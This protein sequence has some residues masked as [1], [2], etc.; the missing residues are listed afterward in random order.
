MNV[1]IV[2][3]L[4]VAEFHCSELILAVWR[5]RKSGKVT[6]RN[7][8][9]SGPLLLA[10]CLAAMEFV[11]GRR[12]VPYTVQATGVGMMVLGE[13]IRKMAVITAGQSFSHQIVEVRQ[14]PEHR[15]V[16]HGI[17]G[18]HRHPSYVGYFVFVIGSMVAL[19]NWICAALFGWVL[20]IF[21]DR[22]LAFEEA[23]LQKRFPEW[24][25]YSR[26]VGCFPFHTYCCKVGE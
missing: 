10:Y 26:R 14:S 3:V 25:A 21:F 12:V 15:L 23:T 5:R 2:V 17:Y 16:T 11:V 8:L 7:A 18:Y 4:F 22:R 24:Q 20:Y 9:V 1:L 19:G 6:W 13:C